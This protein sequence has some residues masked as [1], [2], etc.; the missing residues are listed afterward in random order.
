MLLLAMV[1][2]VVSSAMLRLATLL[3]SQ[4]CELYS[5]VWACLLPSLG[6]VATSNSTWLASLRC[7]AMLNSILC[8]LKLAAGFCVRGELYLMKHV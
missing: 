6:W 8:C 5:V 7:A 1:V 4:S 2:A 3:T